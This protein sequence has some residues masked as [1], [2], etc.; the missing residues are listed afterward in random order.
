MRVLITG[1]GGFAGSHLADLLVADDDCEILGVIRPGGSRANIAH[2]GDRLELIEADLTDE[3][4][5]CRMLA[6]AQPER[7]YHLAAQASVAA[8]W[9]DPAG[10]LQAN[11]L[12]QLYLLSAMSELCPQA[13]VLVVG[14]ADEY[15]RVPSDALPITE[16]C[17]LQP[18]NPYALSKV[19]QDLMAGMF[20]YSHRLHIVRVRPFNHIGPRQRPGFVVPDF[21]RQVALIE[22]GL[23]PPLLKVGNLAAR[24]D[25]CDVRDVVRAYRLALED[26]EKGAVYNICLG[27]SVPIQALL[28]RLLA[29]VQVE[30]QVERDPDRMRP[31]DQPNVVGSAA[32]LNYVTGWRPMVPLAQSLEDTL[33]YWRARVAARGDAA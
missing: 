33:A 2:H 23:Q 11:T 31:S 15:G 3:R 27:T 6:Q 25:F 10:T 19:N 9:A 14:S 29:L 32:L 28:D 13:R 18:T 17:A 1:I 24:R 20:C 5:V 12:P 16:S 26:G 30:I 7:I 22:A 8:S 4:A 21:S